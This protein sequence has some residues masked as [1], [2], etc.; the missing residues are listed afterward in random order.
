MMHRKSHKPTRG[1]DQ[2][3]EYR[4]GVVYRPIDELTLD[5]KNPRLHSKQQI[6]QIARSIAAFGFNV[7]VLLDTQNRVIA[8]HGRMLACQ[9]LGW[10][11]VP[12]IA[13]PHLTE[14]QARAF[15]IADNRL[16]ENSCWNE[17]LLGE[18]LKELAEVHLDFSLEAT[19]FEMGEIDL[20]IEGVAPAPER[21]EDP[22]DT[23]PA[24]AASPPV[25]QRGDLWLLGRHRLLCGNALDDTACA[26]LMED[27][28]A[29]MVFTD[30]PYN[31][32]IDG[33][34]SGLGRV[35]HQDF[36]MA[37]GE[38]S[39]AEFTAFLTQACRLMARSMSEG[40]LAYVCMDWRHLSELLA[41]GRTAF[42][43]FK[44]LCVWD[45]GAGGMGSLYRSQHELVL[46]FKHGTASHR[47][48]IQLGQYGRYRTN[49]WKY[50][51][52]NSFA[53]DTQEGNLLALHPTVK[54][55][56]LVSDAILDASGRNDLVLDPFLGSGTTLI[57][58]ERMGR[59]CYGLELNPQYVDIA[60]R[61][62]QAWTGDR[63]RHAVSGR[64][65]DQLAATGGRCHATRRTR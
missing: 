18:Q 65:F 17:H 51:G 6:R 26:L 45:K 59:R 14:A 46:V 38:M 22:A 32:P 13:L 58:A 4:L 35:R 33:H 60:I 55:V 19:G 27:K 62:W 20:L 24:A 61:R 36:V 52:G 11:E 8:G 29:A 63:A 57:A 42:R 49:V 28:Q 50:P 3:W 5:P 37:S 21:N 64:G 7:P 44:H 10:R 40:A 16:T 56:A 9:E 43:E 48:N 39:E 15:M 34:A 25:S 41:A 47:N 12:T 2:P 54:P 53:R 31:V 1:G 23:I 30:P